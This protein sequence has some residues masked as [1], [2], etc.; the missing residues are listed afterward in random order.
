MTV[1]AGT[2][3]SVGHMYRRMCYKLMIR[4]SA[5]VPGQGQATALTIP[6]PSAWIVRAVACPCPRSPL[7]LLSPSHLLGSGLSLPAFTPREHVPVSHPC[8]PLTHHPRTRLGALISSRYT[9]TRRCRPVWGRTC[10][11]C[12]STLGVPLQRANCRASAPSLRLRRPRCR[13]LAVPTV[14]AP[15]S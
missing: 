2:H 8:S 11:R 12:S 9:R 13:R 15:G 5:G 10:R 14:L 3:S 7:P 1:I 6:P 4:E